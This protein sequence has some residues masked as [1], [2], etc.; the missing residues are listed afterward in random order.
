MQWFAL[1]IPTLLLASD[2][3]NLSGS[4]DVHAKYPNIAPMK[5]VPDSILS[6]ASNP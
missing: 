3:Q 6:L 1:F 4:S 2:R 5:S